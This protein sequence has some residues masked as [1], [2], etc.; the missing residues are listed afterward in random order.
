MAV[1]TQ[2]PQSPNV[3]PGPMT[4]PTKVAPPASTPDGP[5]KQRRVKT[6]T[7]LQMEAVECG[8][9]ALAMV[10]A[11]W[12]VP[13][14]ARE[15]AAR[16][17]QDQEGLR[18][19]HLRDLAREKG[20]DAYVI[21]GDFRDLLRE[22]ERGRPVVVGVAKPYRTK[23]L[24]HYEVVVGLHRGKRLVLTL[25]PARGLRENSWE[26]FAREWVP[27]K[28]VTVVMFPRPRAV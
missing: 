14:P 4:P 28:Q 18:A 20:L 5:R 19:G 17:P 15:I 3:P 26:G 12:Q 2:K 21:S 25:D 11:Y 27:T 16:Y 8:A 22:V 10:L 24:A 6:P 1:S 13:V 23:T 9:A 7:V